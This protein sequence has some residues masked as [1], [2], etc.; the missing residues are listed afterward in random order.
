M[1]EAT[2][3]ELAY[4]ATETTV[5]RGLVASLTQANSRLANS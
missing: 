4:I 3:G 2:I 1:A 5:Y